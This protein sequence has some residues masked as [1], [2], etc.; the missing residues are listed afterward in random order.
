MPPT[1]D[2]AVAGI[3][4][5]A[6]NDEQ[7][8]SALRE[9]IERKGKNAYYFAHSNTPTGPEWDGKPNPKLLGKSASSDD[10]VPRTKPTFEYHKSNITSYAFSDEGKSVKLYL[11]M[12]DV[13]EKCNEEDITLDWT[14]SSF[15]LVLKNYK[16]EEQCL[17][18]GRLTAKISGA[19]YKLKQDKIILT[20]KKEKEGIWHTINDKGS[21]DHEVV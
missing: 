4:Q 10:I 9:N 7:K 8:Q 15:C 14:E 17:S 3:E 5:L 1:E 12:D 20:L 21:P 16:T 2:D 19:T 13:G 11:S 18:F 6:V